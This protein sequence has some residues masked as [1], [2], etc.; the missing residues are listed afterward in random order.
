MFVVSEVFAQN[1]N[2]VSLVLLGARKLIKNAEYAVILKMVI[3]NLLFINLT[4]T[5]LAMT[6]IHSCVSRLISSGRPLIS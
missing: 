2:K 4:F 5:R 6:S 3:V 1:F